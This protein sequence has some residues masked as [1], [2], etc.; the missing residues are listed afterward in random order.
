MRKS[1]VMVLMALCSIGIYAQEQTP[2]QIKAKYKSYDEQAQAEKK[3]GRQQNPQVVINYLDSAIKQRDTYIAKLEEQNEQFKKQLLIPKFFANQESTI[4]EDMTLEDNQLIES[5]V[6]K[7]MEDYKKIVAIRNFAHHIDSIQKK[8]ND[9][10]ASIMSE[11]YSEQTKF[12][13]VRGEVKKDLYDARTELRAI[14][15]MLKN[16]QTGKI[17]T[18]DSG[19]MSA[20]QLEFFQKYEAK[21][22]DLYAKWMMGVK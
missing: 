1:I 4:F 10:L 19:F 11:E 2:E 21:F 20:Q 12:E 13:I 9:K 16:P 7:E 18:N 14:E 22:E 3:K 15:D 6:G 17:E 8:G 5:L